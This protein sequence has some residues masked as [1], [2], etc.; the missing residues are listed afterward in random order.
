METPPFV[1]S[2]FLSF[3]IVISIQHLAFP[4]DT[5][6]VSCVGNSI[7]KAEGLDGADTASFPARLQQMLG[8]GYNVLNCG[9]AGATM[10]KLGNKPY[11]TF[12]ITQF[13]EAMAFLPNIVTIE[14]G[15]NDSKGSGGVDNW[16]SHSGEF[17][18]DYEAMVDTFSYLPTH[19]K[20]WAF[21]PTPAFSTAYLIDSMVIH[22]EILPKIKTVVL[23]KGIPLIDMWTLMSS[24]K[25]LFPDGIHPNAAGYLMMAQKIYGMFMKDTLKVFQQKNRLAAPQN[26]SFYQWYCTDVPVAAAVGGNDEV[27]FAKDTG[28]YRA[29]VGQSTTNDDMLVTNTVHV[30]PSDLNTSILS[31]VNAHSPFMTD[32]GI[33]AIYSITGRLV[34]NVHATKNFTPASLADKLPVKAN[35]VYFLKTGSSVFKLLI[36]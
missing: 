20:V 35:G 31:K 15:T 9:V 22:Y 18:G 27:L 14:L 2:F 7:T 29:L 4:A 25:S 28:L 23:D 11:W 36:K 19:P 17:I 21:Y 24:Q 6:H 26:G 33:V 13:K 5:I 16:P 10:L 1:K 8:S 32:D 3:L 30:S 34:A 12:G